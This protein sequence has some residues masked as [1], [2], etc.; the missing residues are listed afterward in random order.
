MTNKRTWTVGI[1]FVALAVLCASVSFAQPA[2]GG[3]AAKPVADTRG[4]QPAVTAG[5]GAQPGEGET[6]EVIS[7]PPAPRGAMVV[8]GLYGPAGLFR[9]TTTDVGIAHHFR[10]ALRGEGFRKDGFLSGDAEDKN[11]R[12]AGDLM[13]GYTPWRF[14]E[15]YAGWLSTS[16]NNPL[17]KNYAPELINALG[18]LTF[19][20]KGRLPVA[21]GFELGLDFNLRFLNGVSQTYFDGDST[22]VAVNAIASLDFQKYAPKLPLRAHLNV[23]YVH[24]ASK[25]LIDLGQYK[26]C[27]S[28]AGGQPPDPTTCDNLHLVLDYAYG[29]YPSRVRIGLGLDA[30]IRLGKDVTLRPMLEY[31]VDIGTER[32]SYFETRAKSTLSGDRDAATI[33]DNLDGPAMQWL[34][35]GLRFQPLY[36]LSFDF[37]VDLGLASPGYAYGPPVTPWN[38]IFGVAYAYDPVPR[39]ERRTRV[40]TLTREVVRPP[41]EGTVRGV[42]TDFASKKPLPGAVIRLAGRPAT[43]LVTAENGM[44]VSY[45]LQPGAVELEVTREGYAPARAQAV[46]S[47][48]GEAQIEVA[49]NPLPPKPGTVR[50]RI[51]DEVGAP[52]QASVKVT[53][54]QSADLAVNPSTGGY[55]GSLPPGE[56]VVRAEAN[57]YLSRERAVSVATGTVVVIDLGL[58]A[59]PKKSLVELGK[60]EIKVKGTIHFKK[61]GA[62]LDPNSMQLLDEVIDLLARNPQIKRLRVEGHTDNTGKA[63]ANLQLSK[64]RA[65]A[66]MDYLLS[67]G[68]A[69]SRLDSEGFGQTKPLV[70]NIGARNKAKNRRVEFKIL[71]Q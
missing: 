22:N 24:D 19:G 44:F 46:I 27:K 26:P 59:K 60:D 1:A 29:I 68:V 43:G 49:L 2:P 25:N 45:P 50:G 5:A 11:S 13:I 33:K 3:A 12:V 65:K 34:T 55:E 71:E 64:D 10:I 58:R 31:R 21:K 15:V 57:G 63:E 53:G 69:A 48:G 42:V 9:I 62:T 7:Q 52:I 40:T 4:D 17:I 36:G 16:N 61:N 8:P 35:L 30:P 23:G 28:A 67:H 70:P 66:V 56:Y 32:D 39:V 38:I 41:V 18:D 51:T 47:A 54:A 37:G 20:A 6:A 14:L